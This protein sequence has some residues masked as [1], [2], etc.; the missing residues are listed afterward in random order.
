M[1]AQ[2]SESHH[3]R[4]GEARVATN[5]PNIFPV[6]LTHAEFPMNGSLNEIV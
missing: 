4:D 1:R 6:S 2:E 3:H 5:Y